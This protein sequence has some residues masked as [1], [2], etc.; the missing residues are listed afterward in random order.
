MA[1]PSILIVNAG[2]SSLKFALFRAVAKL[3]RLLTGRI[4]RIGQP[5]AVLRIVYP[6]DERLAE[7]R[8]MIHDHAAA[9]PYLLEQMAQLDIRIV[10][11]GHRIVH[12]GVQFRAP[13]TL[14]EETIEALTHLCALSP[15]HMPAALSVIAALRRTYSQVPH[16]ACFDTAFHG[17]L[18]K[19]AAR[20]PIPRRY[21]EKGVR[22]FGFHGLSYAYLMEELGR[23]AG[24]EAAAGRVVLAHLGHGASMAA[25]RA[26]RCIDTTMALTPASGLVMGTRSGDL[27][28]GLGAYL[29]RT[30]GMSPERFYRMTHAESG[31]LGVSETSGDVRDLLSAETSDVRAAEALALFCYQAKKWIGALAAVLGGIDTLVFS[32]GIGEN[33]GPIRAR[34]CEGLAFLGISLDQ[35]ANLEN[36]AIL[37]S[38]D[39]P[40]TVRMLRTDEELYIARTVNRLLPGGPPV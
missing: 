5:D 35:R 20:L 28:P 32:G 2:S 16:V 8:L 39:S 11:V 17:E 15:E 21:E 38:S 4:E 7:L 30:E 31:L 25:V 23:V 36:A 14:T 27:D 22:R 9:V 37:S 29:F 1:Q 13:Q 6:A 24:P 3:D 10:A 18:P 19:E 26:G 40:V 33:A 34:I 12:G